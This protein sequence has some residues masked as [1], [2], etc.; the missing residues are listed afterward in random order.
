MSL[1]AAKSL[2][3]YTHGLRSNGVCLPC[4]EAGRS[5]LA[6]L[7]HKQHNVWSREQKNVLLFL[8]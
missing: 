6:K 4:K 8:Q 7:V 3:W 5:V 2:Y 1:F